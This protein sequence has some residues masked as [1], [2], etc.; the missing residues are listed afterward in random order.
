MSTRQIKIVRKIL[1]GNDAT[2]AQVRQI[3]SEQ[4]WYLINVMGSPGAGKTS[5]IQAM[6]RH[7][8]LPHCGD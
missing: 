3:C 4:E 6:I 1:E 5:F 2:A 7:I 8:D